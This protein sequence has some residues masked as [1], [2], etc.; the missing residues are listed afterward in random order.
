TAATG[1]TVLDGVI[2]GG[3]YDY[4]TQTGWKSNSSRTRWNYRNGLGGI[5]G[6][7][8]VALKIGSSPWLL[9]FSASG[10]NGTYAVA[11]TG[12]PVQ[13]T[14]AVDASA[15]QCGEVSFAGPPPS[16]SC[17]FS[18]SGPTCAAPRTCSAQPRPRASAASCTSPRC[19]PTCDPPPLA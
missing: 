2:P 6:I 4:A 11:P 19:R 8:K 18:S 1:A 7:V 13:L 14:F 12:L 5:G 9:Q 17:A 3:P 10:R 16:P 15:G